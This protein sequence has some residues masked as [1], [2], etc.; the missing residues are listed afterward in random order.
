[1]WCVGDVDHK[2]Y[3]SGGDNNVLFLNSVVRIDFFGTSF[4]FSVVGIMSSIFVHGL[5]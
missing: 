5:V 2:Y 1:M 4:C 3:S